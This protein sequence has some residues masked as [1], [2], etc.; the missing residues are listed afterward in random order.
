MSRSPDTSGMLESEAIEITGPSTDTNTFGRLILKDTEPQSSE[1]EENHG[2]LI[3]VVHITVLSPLENRHRL[4]DLFTL[5]DGTKKRELVFQSHLSNFLAGDLVEE[6]VQQEATCLLRD[7][8]AARVGKTESPR[9]AIVFV[10][11]DLGALVVKRA[12]SIASGFQNEYSSIFWDTSRL[13]F[14]GC[15]QRGVG[16]WDLVTRL[17]ALLSGKLDLQVQC[18]LT[19]QAIES[20]AHVTIQA[21]EEFIGSKIALRTR[22]IHLYAGEDEAGMIHPS[23]D[24]FAAT[25]GLS[26]EIAVQERS[27]NDSTPRFPSLTNMV[28]YNPKHLVSDPK[29]LPVEQAL[30][31][32]AALPRTSQHD[33]RQVTI[34]QSALDAQEYTD[35]KS[36]RGPQ[37]LYVRGNSHYFTH[38]VADQIMLKDVA[39][40]IQRKSYS[41]RRFVSFSF[42]SRDPQRRSIPDMMNSI[43]VQA[44]S[45]N[46]TGTIDAVFYM[47]HNLFVMRC[48]W[49]DESCISMFEALW[50][51]LFNI[52]G[53]TMILHDFDECN[54][55]SR[56]A[57]MEYFSALAKRTEIPFKLVITSREPNSL[58][59]ELEE[60]PKLDVDAHI[61]DT[62]SKVRSLL[63]DTIQLCPSEK[64]KQEIQKSLGK[65]S[66]MR[67]P[68]LNVIL[69]LLCNHTSWPNSPSSHSLSKFT[70]LLSLVSPSDTPERVLDRIIRSDKHAT[71]LR[72]ALNWLLCSYRPLSPKE[73][74]AVM[75]NHM[76]FESSGLELS[77]PSVQQLRTWIHM[78]TDFK[79]GQAT[80]RPC[81][82]RLLVGNEENVSYVWNQVMDEAHQNL[83]EFC[84]TYLLSDSATES[85]KHTVLK[86]ESVVQQQHQPFEAAN[87]VLPRQEGMLL[88]AV[89]ALPYHLSKCSSNYRANALSSLS[90][91]S[92]P[93]AST[94]WAKTYWAMSN[95][96]SRTLAPPESALPL[97]A[98]LGFLNY[99]ELSTETESL[100]IQCLSSSIISGIGSEFLNLCSPRI[101]SIS[102]SIMLL[103]SALQAN[104]QTMALDLAQGVL[105]HPEWDTQTQN[106]WPRVAIWTAVWFNMVDLARMLLENGVS[107]NTD[108][109]GEPAIGYYPSLLYLSSILNRHDIVDILLARNASSKALPNA[110]AYG[111]FEA[112]AYRGHIEVVQQFVGHSVSQIHER[113]PPTALFGASLWGAWESVRVLI[114]AGAALNE[115]QGNPSGDD[116]RLWTPLAAACYRGFPKTMEA[117]LIRGANVNA[118][119][120]W[121]ADTALWF[122]AFFSPD[123]KRVRVMLKYN[124]DPNHQSFNPPLLV[125]IA[126][127]SENKAL[128]L[129]IFDALFQGKRP[130]DLNATNS[131]GKTALMVA[132]G[133]G[134]LDFVNWLLMNGADIDMLDRQNKSALYYGVVNGNADL[135]AA[136]L[137][138]GAR[139]D[140][141]H[142]SGKST[143]LFDSISRP[144]IVRHLMRHGA[145]A[146]IA[147]E[148]GNTAINLVSASGN[149]EVARILIENGANIE[150]KNMFGWAPI[151]DAVATSRNTALVRLLVENGAKTDGMVNG[152]GLLH[153][154]INGDLEIL[155]ILLEFRKGIDINAL[156]KDGCAAVHLAAEKNDIRYLQTLIRAGADLNILGSNALTVLHYAAR[157][158][159][160]IGHLKLLLAQPDIEVD[161]ISPKRGTPLCVASE[162]LNVEGV[163]RL[164]DAGADIN[165]SEANI[166]HSTPLISALSTWGYTTREKD[167]RTMDTII[168]MMVS[169]S[170]HKADVRRTVHGGYFYTALAAACL[171]AS[172][173]T[174]KFLIEE[175]AEV[176]LVDAVSGRLP[177][178]YAAA[179]GF[180]NF[181]AIILS[182][183]G[184]MMVSDNEK[185]N[186]LHWAAQ[187]GNLR[188]VEFIISRL[189]SQRKLARYINQADSDGWTPLCWAARPCKNIRVKNMRSE[190]PDFADVVETLLRNGA[191][192]DVKCRLGNGTDTEELTPL[193]LARR[194]D[195]DKGI[196]TMLQHGV[197]DQAGSKTRTGIVVKGPVRIY[198]LHNLFCTICF[199]DV[200]GLVFRCN[201]CANY[202]ICGKCWPHR[203]T[204]HSA[205]T[206]GDG[207]EHKLEQSADHAEYQHKLGGEV[208]DGDGDGD[209]AKQHGQ[210]G[211]D[212]IEAGNGEASQ[213]SEEEILDVEDIEI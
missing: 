150:H 149:L 63:D 194:C 190:Q 88:Y 116:A 26:S 138:K 77:A 183:R 130:I 6:F 153:R 125:E 54:R 71:R 171:S 25:I 198:A 12:L 47:L 180:N 39:E 8:L 152:S 131:L 203:E 18:L 213:E 11:Y 102:T 10:A 100:Q 107:V 40:L 103:L 122:P 209:E 143:L 182:Y 132:S 141:A 140:V 120:A 112:A 160:N 55:E 92:N 151:L 128:Y 114:E 9:K 94:L 30:L 129:P 99:G 105:S 144:E 85:L 33:P 59:A 87:L 21:N 191:Q 45:G 70:H 142:G 51:Y 43:L 4:S 27:K 161:I 133:S 118:P 14:S 109:N 74:A 68:T 5:K 37:A 207:K 50:P 158:S 139:V 29:W 189:K 201:S 156:D 146:N 31:A 76:K 186:C 15:L 172:P 16:I 48:G 42:D 65:L 145:D 115:P 38:S 24:A 170:P 169:N 187:F 134:K 1:D 211:N 181:Q 174:L 89:Q 157:E 101:S 210:A 53:V 84:L 96:V 19:S 205:K 111:S 113:Q 193:E 188:T 199:N 41:S 61:T 148:S 36:F 147:N 64:R 91:K 78:L 126:G 104:D 154:A 167:L 93:T 34:L 62:T 7:L 75:E 23:M 179:N 123:V 136:L 2:L 202:G 197:G 66:A 67:N 72:W 195:A 177:H 162:R 83:A 121:K 46:F 165:F 80:I 3:D 117:L 49:T 137:K 206:Q 20:L 119:C 98:S 13:I 97:Y 127:S 164:L 52:G 17:W 124:A 57:F 60:W 79:D 90:D 196:I 166:L 106:T 200:L 176:D 173:A 212:G 184:D 44:I 163:R 22:I 86:Y 28:A 192:I 69:E 135:V 108:P 32:L 159:K 81:L 110:S 168:R 178:H 35:W 155:K 58:T 204:F 82:M 95:P 175:G 185:K 73:L 208:N 56:T